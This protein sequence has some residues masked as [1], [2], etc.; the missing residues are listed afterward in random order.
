MA[1][2]DQC[3]NSE[4]ERRLYRV[5]IED[6]AT[7]D[8]ILLNDSCMDQQL[9]CQTMR[10]DKSSFFDKYPDLNK[11]EVDESGRCPLSARWDKI[12]IKKNKFKTFPKGCLKDISKSW[13]FDRKGVKISNSSAYYPDSDERSNESK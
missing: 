1:I 10:Y 8:P 5:Q 6:Q 13:R 3:D 7:Q 4:W 12:R 2:V 11:S 9:G